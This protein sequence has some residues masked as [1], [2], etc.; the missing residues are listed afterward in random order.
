[1]NT[2]KTAFVTATL[3]AV[4]YGAKVVLDSPKGQENGIADEGGAPLSLMA[5]GNPASPPPGGAVELP[6]VSEGDFAPDFAAS[7]ATA[8]DGAGPIPWASSPSGSSEIPAM[9]PAL[10]NASHGS[11]V[12]PSEMP[13]PVPVSGGERMSQDGGLLSNPLAAPPSQF[14]EIRQATLTVPDARFGPP[15]EEGALPPG[16]ASPF[17]EMWQTAQQRLQSGDLAE[18]LFKLSLLYAKDDLTAEQRSRVIPLLDQLAGTVIYSQQH[19]LEP[20]RTCRPGEQLA[21][22]A[23]EYGVPVSF[24]ARVNGLDPRQPLAGGQNLKVVRGP[25]RGELSLSRRELTVFLGRNYAGRFTVAV[26]R[27]APTQPMTL[28]VTEKTG[29]RAYVDTMT[30]QSIPPGAPHNPYGQHWLGLSPTNPQWGIHSSGTTIDA[31]DARG[32][33]SVSEADADDLQAILSEGA[34]LDLVP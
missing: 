18:A 12:P 20:P 33:L 9:P 29:P 27:D 3:I 24:L 32:C 15:A 34:Q 23:T 10:A 22:V 8:G 1:M 21:D 11:S 31:A 30:Q 6:P 25:F 7:Q 5:G 28:Y 2:I 26:G 19:F 17:E 4:A 16:G 13:T 14:G